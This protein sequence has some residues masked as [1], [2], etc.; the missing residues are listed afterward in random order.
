MTVLALAL[1]ALVVVGDGAPQPLTDTAGDATRG[2]AIVVNRQQGLCLL[3]HNGPNVFAEVREQG[4]LASNLEGAGTRWT[5]AQ[6]RWRVADARRLDPN[7]LMPSFYRSEGLSQV[8]RAWV[9]QT[10]LSAQEIEDV[11]AFLQTLK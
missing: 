6:L 1:L 9:G 5:A 11:V 8:G 7:G 2:R 4:N 3:C 10:V